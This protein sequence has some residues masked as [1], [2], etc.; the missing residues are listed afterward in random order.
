MKNGK[1]GVGRELQTGTTAVVIEAIQRETG[2]IGEKREVT[3]SDPI[4]A[5]MNALTENKT[6]ESNNP[7][8]T[9][10]DARI[11]TLVPKE[12]SSILYS[13]RTRSRRQIA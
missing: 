10:H 6:R 13:A 2:M 4:L 8:R 1:Y 5:K 11:A 7:P 12:K 3:P 9:Q